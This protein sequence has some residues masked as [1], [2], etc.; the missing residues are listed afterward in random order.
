MRATAWSLDEFAMSADFG[1]FTPPESA[2]PERPAAE[3]EAEVQ[4]RLAASLQLLSPRTLLHLRSSEPA[5]FSITQGTPAR[6]A[7]SAS[8][9]AAH[10]PRPWTS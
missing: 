7:D 3:I 10:G 2:T 8:R 9:T 5:G 4:A 1:A 6:S